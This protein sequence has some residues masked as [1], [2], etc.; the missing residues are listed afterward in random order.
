VTAA[1][2]EDDF[3]RR[4]YCV[5]GVPVD[6]ISMPELVSRIHRATSK[7]EPLFL[8]TPNLN[9][10]MLAQR[11]RDFRRSLL[12][13][14]LC[15]ADGVGVLLICKLLG[16]PITSRVAGS[17]LPAALRTIQTSDGRGLRLALLGGEPGVAE[18]AREAINAGDTERLKCVAAID[19]GVVTADK[20]SNP[21]VLEQVNASEADLL[22]VA[23]GAQKGQAWLMANRAKLSVPVVSHLGATLNF[24]AGTIRRAPPAVQ[25][26]GLEWLWR[27]MQEP[28][29]A[30]RYLGDGVRLGWVV[31]TRVLPLS[32]WLQRSRKDAA[33]LGNGIWLELE[34]HRYC[35]VV[36]AG[37]L[38]DGRLA[39]VSK[40]FRDAAQTGRDIRLDFS[41]LQSFG[42]G[43]AGQ[44]LV[45]E[46]VLG[47]KKR[48][49]ILAATPSVRRALRWCGLG[50]LHD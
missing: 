48:L 28:K 36:L 29:L 38:D 6:K 42:L 2:P 23:L 7:R 33:Q 22:M 13:S 35:A 50:H 1:D 40:A 16:I 19:P 12:E 18:R 3:S 49:T 11:D 30:S 4:V 21:A 41:R 20:M 31:L 34:L 15:P 25:K 9:Y 5:L 43:L 8:S 39:P 24:L 46:K 27:I 14:D 45:L 17:D 37:N 26:I 44:I 10:L 47:S 32:I